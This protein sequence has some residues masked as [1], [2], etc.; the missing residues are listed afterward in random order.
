M[1]NY[2]SAKREIILG[3]QYCGEK[4]EN[5]RIGGE[6]NFKIIRVWGMFKAVLYWFKQHNCLIS[7]RIASG[8]HWW[9]CNNSGYESMK[10]NAL[11]S[12]LALSFLFLSSTNL[13]MWLWSQRYW[14]Y[15]RCCNRKGLWPACPGALSVLSFSCQ[16]NGR[17]QTRLETGAPLLWS[18]LS[19]P[20]EFSIR[21][22]CRF[23]RNCLKWIY[24]IYGRYISEPERKG[25]WIFLHW[26]I[27]N[28]CI[29]AN[30]TPHFFVRVIFF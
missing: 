22:Y 25:D 17:P 26:T 29:I 23:K 13:Q 4:F 28:N 21:A 12:W 11:F 24:W 2:T 19:D 9:L 6:D 27:G 3:G 18:R 14:R 7:R 1:S 15:R 8:F 20:R 30:H 10:I 5:C 16:S